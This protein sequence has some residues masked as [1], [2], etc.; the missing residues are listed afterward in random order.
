MKIMVRTNGGG[1][2]FFGKKE[3]DS[4]DNVKI[5]IFTSVDK[6]MARWQIR[7][8]CVDVIEPEYPHPSDRGAYRGDFLLINFDDPVPSEAVTSL[9]KEI[10]AQIPYVN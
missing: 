9:I 4:F 10:D 5:G 2:V 3:F 7:M 1:Q 6:M 8:T